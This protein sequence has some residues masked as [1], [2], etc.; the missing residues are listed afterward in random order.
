MP[1]QEEIRKEYESDPWGFTAKAYAT[2]NRSMDDIK[3]TVAPEDMGIGE[4]DFIPDRFNTPEN[5]RRLKAQIR[6]NKK[7][8]EAF[9]HDRALWNSDEKDEDIPGYRDYDDEE[10]EAKR[11]VADIQT[12][13]WVDPDWIKKQKGNTT[14]GL[15]NFEDYDVGKRERPETWQGHEKLR[16]ECDDAIQ[17]AV[18]DGD[19]TDD[20][21]LQNFK[22]LGM[23]PNNPPGHGG[24]NP[25]W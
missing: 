15:M 22:A 3:V 2:R 13:G 16:K 14:E 20:A 21:T 5:V 18:W 19:K 10:A 25:N 12:D 23:L 6:E 8:K 24:Y 7:K 17:N 11:K 9:E 1:D 4:K